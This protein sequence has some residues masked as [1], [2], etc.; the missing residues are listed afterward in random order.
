MQLS[1]RYFIV[2]LQDFCFKKIK[3][4]TIKDVAEEHTYQM[5]A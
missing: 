5:L 3:L 2:L 4:E 1:S